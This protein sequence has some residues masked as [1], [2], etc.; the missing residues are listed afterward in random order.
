M[1]TLGRYQLVKKLA[2]GGMAELFLARTAGP[3]GFEKHVAVKVILPHLADEPRFVQML[4]SEARLAARLNHPNIVHI[5]DF[6]AVEQTYFI[7]MELIDGPDMKVL[8][9]EALRQG[10]TVPHTVA[11]KIVALAAEGLAYAH[12]FVDPAT[13]QPMNVIHRDMSADNLLVS[14]TG[15]VKIVDFGVAKIASTAMST[16]TGQLKGKFA[17]TSP[18]Q[19]RGEPLDGRTDVFS[20]GM[21][22]YELIAG[23]KPFDTTSDA[24]TMQA[25]VHDRFAPLTKF[26][27]DAPPELQ[28]IVDR[29]L[30]KSRDDRYA[31]GLEFAQDLDAFIAWTGEPVGSYQLAQLV[32]TVMGPV[33]SLSLGGPPAPPSQSVPRPAPR[34]M[35]SAVAPP[36]LPPVRSPPPPLSI[37]ELLSSELEKLDPSY[38][39]PVLEEPVTRVWPTDHALPPTP[40]RPRRRRWGAPLSAF[41]LGLLFTTCFYT[42]MWDRPLAKEQFA[43]LVASTA[44]AR[45]TVNEWLG[46]Q[47]PPPPMLAT[48]L[49][50]V[51]PDAGAALPPEGP[52]PKSLSG[53]GDSSTPPEVAPDPSPGPEAPTGRSAAPVA[54]TSPRPRH[55]HSRHATTGA[56]E[57]SPDGRAGPGEGPS[58]EAAEPSGSADFRERPSQG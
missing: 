32:K 14:R 1:R 19:F 46:L 10:L 37:E 50:P 43:R 39:L 18:E 29:A 47:G 31:D 57:E 9:R 51:A 22:L 16:R 56:G 17:Y 36:L 15:A 53:D 12:S 5:F 8:L 7:A 42:W 20:L 41:L 13:D 44:S 33:S 25:V 11:A 35:E 30:A 26:R 38:D 27:P 23:Q 55:H 49:A 28:H 4:L 6:G 54:K 45:A 24:A 52:I 58:P 48:P 3:G 2:T 21:V 40:D 34:P